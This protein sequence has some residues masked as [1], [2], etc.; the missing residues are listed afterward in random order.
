MTHTI[1]YGNIKQNKQTT[2]ITNV[3]YTIYNSFYI[4]LIPQNKYIDNTIVNRK[5]KR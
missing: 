4:N 2:I 1:N 3:F 5:K